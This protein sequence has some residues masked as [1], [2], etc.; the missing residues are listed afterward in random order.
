MS[1]L[2]Q[3]KCLRRTLFIC[4][5]SFFKIYVR[6][7]KD[8]GDRTAQGTRQDKS[9]M[10]FMW[11]PKETCLCLSSRRI[12]L[13]TLLFSHFFIKSF[14]TTNL[15]HR[16]CKLSPPDKDSSS[17]AKSLSLSLSLCG[18]NRKI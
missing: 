14:P 5:F 4:F 15:L 12:V 11:L 1:C 10:E 9:N 2:G 6:K 16:T 3:Y 7:R 18:R 13:T 8:C 17:T